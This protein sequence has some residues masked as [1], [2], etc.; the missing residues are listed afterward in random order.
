MTLGLGSPPL[1]PVA[2]PV[3]FAPL[4]RK[5]AIATPLCLRRGQVSVSSRSGAGGEPGLTPG[6]YSYLVSVESGRLPSS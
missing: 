6:C 3:P 2:S 1:G 4:G 5:A